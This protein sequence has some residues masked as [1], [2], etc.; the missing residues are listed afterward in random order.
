MRCEICGA[1]L[2]TGLTV[3]DM[4]NERRQSTTGRFRTGSNPPD[5][6][7]HFRPTIPS[8]GHYA[9]AEGKGGIILE[10][11]YRLRE[12]IGRGAMGTVFLAEDITLMR[13]VAVKFLLPELAHSKECAERF[14]NE[15][16]GMA[17]IRD[18]NVA[19]IHAYGK[20]GNNPY[21]VMEYKKQHTS[22][23]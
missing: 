9:G 18:V 2:D 22:D 17:A 6:N 19:Q 1:P 7:E 21:F 12:E 23:S 10:G 16:I 3:C 11:K 14:K 20:H 4:C 8:A 5:S 13:K 15:A